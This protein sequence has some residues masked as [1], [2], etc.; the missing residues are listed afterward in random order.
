M[1]ATDVPMLSVGE[2][3][4]ALRDLRARHSTAHTRST[5][6]RS[7]SVCRGSDTAVTCGDDWS[8]TAP[9]VSDL[10]QNRWGPEW[11]AV[12]AAHAGAG[13]SSVA[14]MVTDALS[15]AGRPTRLVEVADPTWSG[16]VAA[17]DAE[18][19]VDTSAGWRRGRRGRAVLYRRA[20]RGPLVGWPVGG[21]GGMTVADLG[22]PAAGD[23]ERLAR[24]RPRLVV[25]CR[26]TVPGARRAAGLLGQLAY[27]GGAPLVVAAVGV[28][29]WPGP[30]TAAG[31]RELRRLKAAGR[32][33]AV[34]LDRRLQTTGLT[35]DPLSRPLLAAGR[36]L[37]DR[38][39][40][41]VR[42]GDDDAADRPPRTAKEFR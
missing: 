38:I 25:V 27:P 28:R 33:V 4:S 35:A 18:L 29:H 34:P 21:D 1:S 12:V 22:L 30:V 26:T 24:H 39:C 15:A 14:L 17:A 6:S 16:L 3:Q 37:V 10:D 8:D 19:G 2:I 11:V 20:R 42:D 13:A 31:G 9:G 7:D 41:V 5:A 32:V 36:A 23:V 40:P